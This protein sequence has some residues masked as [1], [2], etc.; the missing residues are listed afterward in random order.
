MGISS[1]AVNSTRALPKESIRL[2]P[3]SCQPKKNILFLKTHKTG[4]STIQNI[5]MR[6]GYH[7][8]LTFVLPKSKNYFGHPTAFHRSMIGMKSSRSKRNQS[9]LTSSYN[10]LTHHTRL[11]YYEMKS[12]MP[13]DTFFITILRDP[14]CL[15]ESVFC[16]FRIR[17]RSTKTSC[18]DYMVQYFETWPNTPTPNYLSTQRVSGRYGLNQM[19]FDLGLASQYF[20]RSK[21]IEK[22]IK[23]LDSQ[24]HL[25]MI[26]DRMEESLVLLQDLL[27]W[28]LDDIIAFKLN[29]RAK[30]ENCSFSAK[31]QSKIRMVNA[32][33]QMLYDFFHAKLMRQIVAYGETKMKEKVAL[34]R[35][36]T[37]VM[38]KK[39]ARG[40]KLSSK[41]MSYSKLVAQSQQTQTMKKMCAFR[42]IRE[43]DFTDIL[44][45]KARSWRVNTD[46]E[47]LNKDLTNVRTYLSAEQPPLFKPSAE[48]WRISMTFSQHDFHVTISSA[49]WICSDNQ[50]E[51]T[52][53]RRRCFSRILDK[54]TIFAFLPQLRG[55][56]GGLDLN[57]SFSLWS[58]KT[59]QRSEI[60][61]NEASPPLAGFSGNTN[62]LL[63]MLDFY[64]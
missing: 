37:E 53:A 9:S 29:S 12:V 20:N 7:H 21:L 49:K 34:L 50:K 24:F 14:V 10:I 63:R 36:A 45:E 25:V 31:I 38:G 61:G 16:Y 42:S 17:P 23:K 18:T 13:E 1:R 3:A 64:Y 57:Q 33:D 48:C 41:G 28:S 5:F 11:D 6:Y 22:F 51:M 55:S 47:E 40:T 4:S 26:L 56:S 43:M 8:N 19:S 46:V 62:G 60:V 35:N 54:A 15:T 44:R 32:A 2:L 39:C 30:T 27:C 58:R 59:Q 52:R